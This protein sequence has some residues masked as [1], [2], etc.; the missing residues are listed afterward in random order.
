MQ[1]LMAKSLALTAG[2]ILAQEGR[3][4]VFGILEIPS[5]VDT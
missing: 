3:S 5:C 1:M 2:E 4:P